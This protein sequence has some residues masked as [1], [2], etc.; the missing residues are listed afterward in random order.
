MSTKRAHRVALATALTAILSGCINGGSPSDEDTASPGPAVEEPETVVADGACDWLGFEELDT[1]GAEFGYEPTLE[2]YHEDGGCSKRLGRVVDGTER[3]TIVFGAKAYEFS[4]AEA[5]ATAYQDWIANHG[6]LL[7]TTSENTEQFEVS[8]MWD[9][10]AITANLV[11]S[12]GPELRMLVRTERFLVSYRARLSVKGN[13]DECGASGVSDCAIGPATVLDWFAESWAP[14]AA[15]RL[16]T[17][18]PP[19]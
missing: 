4:D 11:W 8:E 13:V 7:L 6:H 2:E 14:Q 9:E 15:E 16:V 17:E 18:L 19:G 3:E 12:D 1:L 10:G 5:A